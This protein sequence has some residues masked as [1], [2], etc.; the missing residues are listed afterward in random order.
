M[1]VRVHYFN[2]NRCQNL[3]G[4]WIDRVL[5]D[6]GLSVILLP[7]YIYK[8]L[9][10][11]ELK[12]T[13]VTL[14]LANHSIKVSRGIIEDVFIQVDTVY[15]LVDFIILDTQP[16][17]CE[18]SKRHILAIL[19]RPFLATANAFIYC[20]NELLKLSFGNITLETN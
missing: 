18:S 12:P 7:Y 16:V 15:Y 1:T 2:A 3:R 8:E 4:Y 19:G 17:E 11:G 6:L 13:C 20:R 10:L 5:L 14:K 9:G